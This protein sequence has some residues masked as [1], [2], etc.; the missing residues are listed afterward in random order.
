MSSGSVNPT[1]FI[2][3]G[4]H[5]GSVIIP[6]P[7]IDSAFFIQPGSDVI[8]QN[9]AFAAGRKPG[10]GKKQSVI[11]GSTA[12]GQKV[13]VVDCSVSGFSQDLSGIIW[14]NVQFDR[15]DIEVGGGE[16][17]L[18]HV[19]FTNCKIV[20]NRQIGRLIAATSGQDISFS[21]ALPID[22]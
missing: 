9:L 16:L 7:S 13:I 12:R 17:N 11:L 22:S 5:R 10:A 20:E 3:V 14:V 2:G 15:C 6:A 1:R 18:L 21:S 4:S 8:L 19:S